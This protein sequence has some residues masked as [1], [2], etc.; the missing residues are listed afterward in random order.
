LEHEQNQENRNFLNYGIDL[1]T[2]NSCIAK[3]EDDNVRI[4]Q[5]RDNTN[6]TRS[7]VYIRKQNKRVVGLRAFN[8]LYNDPANVAVEFKRLMGTNHNKYFPSTEISLTP[9]ELS[10]EILKSLKGDVQR[11]IGTNINSAVITVPAFFGTLQ[12]EAT[13]KAA[14]LSGIENVHLLQEPI[15]AAI[16]YGVE[17]Q[18]K[19]NYWMVYDLGGGT[20]DVA[21][22]STYHGRLTVL[23]NEGNNYLGGKDIDELIVEKIFIPNIEAKYMM[24]DNNSEEY[25]SLKRKLLLIAED[26]KIEL[27]NLNSSIAYIDDVGE[28]N[29]GV[30]INLEIEVTIECLDSLLEN[31]IKETLSLS[32]KVLEGAN[33]TRE[34]LS[35]IL[36]VGGST[37][38]TAIRNKLKEYFQVDL[39]Y[40]LDPITVVGKGA[41]IYAS[42]N[43]TEQKKNIPV[44]SAG[45][46][47]VDLDFDSVTA[48]LSS[49]VAG[50]FHGDFNKYEVCIESTDGFWTSGWFFLE[51]EE[52]K[53]FEVEVRLQ[54]NKNNDF[55]VRARDENGEYLDV[56]G[57]SFRIKHME[58]HL[59]LTKP[60]VPHSLAVEYIDN[61]GNSKLEP[62]IPKNN[63]L[64]AFGTYVFKT[65]K[66]IR[67]RQDSEYITIKLWEGENFDEPEANK[68]VANLYITSKDLE[69]PLPKGTDVEI[70]LEVD[71]SRKISI[72][73]SIPDI[74]KD[75]D[76]SEFYNP[77]PINTDDRFDQISEEIEES[78]KRLE[79]IDNKIPYSEVK[80]RKIFD[81][82]YDELE[83]FSIQYN[84]EYELCKNDKD[85]AHRL[86]EKAKSIRCK[87]L[88]QEKDVLVDKR[89]QHIEND[90]IGTINRVDY[91]VGNFGDP[92]EKEQ[93]E[94]LKNE[95]QQAT[96]FE[97]SRGSRY[98]TKKMEDL[99][100]D[101]LMRR[102][103][104]WQQL[105]YYICEDE[106]KGN[107]V[108]N[109]EAQ[110]W[111]AEGKNAEKNKN[112]DKLRIA[113]KNLYKL[114]KKD[115]KQVIEEG[116]IQPGLKK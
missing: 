100:V 9:E 60:L 7:A 38:I 16:A 17:T 79:Y 116:S 59:S 22:I 26:V 40:S 92:A 37:Q 4:F 5:T 34:E 55:V 18:A 42:L 97:D 61:E 30:E 75:F 81:K 106:S 21:V 113:V 51:D 12:C 35:K 74:S 70:S 49:I 93:F 103:D 80:K 57:G 50:V 1:G 99:E 85:R 23:N 84:E 86:I 114:V 6:T 109:S 62:I 105:F 94:E 11:L 58:Q 73:A 39:D 64:P 98:A 101:I 29:E 10:A 25:R 111:I 71:E 107:F 102:Y 47:L 54:Q 24:F 88:N 63:T 56:E 41:A 104:F 95:W 14:Q 72:F 53:L 108:N 66:E 96:E 65:S 36:L 15:A 43:L 90:A 52:E 110:K 68:W 69:R 44:I 82:I 77:T 28:D 45:N 78:F 2:T 115:I 32:D 76:K 89:Q 33:I 3:M 48:D 83:D 8:A 19:N 31:I 13:Y 112:T 67:T 91:T 87:I 20:F 27:S 46:L